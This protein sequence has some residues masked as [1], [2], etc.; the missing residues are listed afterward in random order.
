MWSTVR[1]TMLLLKT[2]LEH[3]SSR[4]GPLKS[5]TFKMAAWHYESNIFGNFKDSGLQ[6]YKKKNGKLARHPLAAKRN[7]TKDNEG[8]WPNA[9]A[10]CRS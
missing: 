9:K 1:R 3:L 4:P 7:Q 10:F 8:S 2:S 6:P 5:L